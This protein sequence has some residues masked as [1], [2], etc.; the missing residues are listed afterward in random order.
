M[1]QHRD[2]MLSRSRAVALGAAFMCCALLVVIAGVEPAA[3]AEPP[4]QLRV[5]AG[6]RS[7]EA[8]L[9]QFCGPPTEEELTGCQI[10]SLVAGFQFPAL[11]AP[12][13]SEVVID[14]GLEATTVTVA[15]SRPSGA[16]EDPAAPARRIDGRRWAF[17]MPSANARASIDVEYADGGSSS[18]LLTLRRI[19][20]D[21]EGRSSIDAHG[22]VVIWSERQEESG[23]QS[24]SYHL[25]AM[26]QDGVGRL[27]VAPRS[28]PF[29][30]DLGP[31][32][33][34][35]L[36]AVYSRCEREPSTDDPGFVYAMP[37]PAYTRGD[38]CDIYRFDFATERERKVAG[39]STDQASE[40]LPS[41]WGDSIAFARVYERSGERGRVPH[42]YVRPL[43]GGSS[44]R[45]PGGSRGASGLPG[46]VSLDLYGR[47][48]SFV[49]NYATGRGSGDS[50]GV[51]EVRLDTIGGSHRVLSQAGHE[52]T[53]GGASYASFLS[54]QG[55]D[56]RVVYGYQRVDIQASRSR[57]RS[58]TAVI[59]MRCAGPRCLAPTSCCATA[60]PRATR[61]SS[62]RPRASPA[63]PPPGVTTPSTSPSAATSSPGT[64]ARPSSTSAT[65]ASAERLRP[66][67]APRHV[68]TGPIIA[69]VATVSFDCYRE[70]P[71]M[72]G[73]AP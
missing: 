44:Q 34:G 2:E 49:W 56:G 7:A 17:V 51:S 23:S 30:V 40:V 1:R 20:A 72:P 35:R 60:S 33:G 50:G 54:P 62:G 61:A 58:R 32:E 37:Y 6:E 9:E 66:P 25:T 46:P 42:L 63:W 29:D 28:V 43:A 36:M 65:W 12:P 47:R 22:D 13:G 19:V 41:I 16:G 71:Y 27:P 24:G 5:T 4:P 31:D 52:G 21:S 57:S 53:G 45:Q 70:T 67:G 10:S 39:A 18:S 8:F 14:T 26:T 55:V 3:A 38:G 11:A 69:V 64:A 48:L 68:P 15:L 59:A 73:D